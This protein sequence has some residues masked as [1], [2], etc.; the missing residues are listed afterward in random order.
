MAPYKQK[1]IANTSTTS[2]K[3]PRVTR[4]GVTSQAPLT[5]PDAYDAKTFWNQIV[6]MNSQ[7]VFTFGY[8]ESDNNEH[9]NVVQ[10][11]CSVREYHFDNVCICFTKDVD[12]YLLI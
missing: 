1:H 5:I 3:K 4:R 7:K 6:W 10:V 11:L 9:H 8:D 2:N 12:S